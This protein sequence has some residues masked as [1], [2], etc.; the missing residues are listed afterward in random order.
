[1]KRAGSDLKG[2]SRPLAWFICSSISVILWT[3]K[4]TFLKELFQ[5]VLEFTTSVS[6]CY[7]S[8]LKS[9]K[10]LQFLRHTSLA[11]PVLTASPF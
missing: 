6:F 8:L 3:Q 11:M 1:M 9:I 2:F 5:S 7:S 10:H 4:D